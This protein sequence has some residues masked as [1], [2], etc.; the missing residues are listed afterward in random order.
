MNVDALVNAMPRPVR[1]AA[2]AVA[3]VACAAYIVLMILGATEL[4]ERLHSLG[5]DARDLPVRRWILMLMLPTG[6][7]LLG[8]RLLQV[9]AEVVHGT[10]DTLGT[11]HG[12]K[13]EAG[14]LT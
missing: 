8:I 9:A 7:T 2:T 13:R 3:I 10:R 11:A 6:F 14:P 4:V 12:P 1:R 5:S